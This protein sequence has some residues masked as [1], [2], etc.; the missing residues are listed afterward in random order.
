MC[1]GNT[2]KLHTHCAEFSVNSKLLNLSTPY[3]IFNH[4]FQADLIKHIVYKTKIAYKQTQVVTVIH[5]KIVNSVK[6]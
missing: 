5:G 6:L 3:Q 1:C 4:Y 2:K